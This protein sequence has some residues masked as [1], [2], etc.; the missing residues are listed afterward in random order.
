M[1]MRMSVVVAVAVLGGTWS[2]RADE[3]GAGAGAEVVASPIR[4]EVVLAEPLDPAG[5]VG[6]LV[7]YVV[8]EGSG[9][10]GRT[11]PAA[12]PFFSSPQPMFGVD[13]RGWDEGRKVVI[14][15]AC[16]A[17][18]FPGPGVALEP[19]EYRVQAVLDRKRESSSWSAEEGNLYST[20]SRFTVASGQPLVVPIELGR[21]IPKAPAPRR[22]GLRVFEMVS[23]RL[24]AFHG[25]EVVMR[26]GVVE[27]VDF[28][29]G[30]SYAA[31]YEIPGFGGT[32]RGAAR[33]ARRRAELNPGS[34]EYEL[35]RSTYLIV[36]DPESGN[37]HHLFCDS[38]VNGPR[39]AALVEELIPAL[40]AELSLIDD[41]GA[42]IVTGHSSGGW[43]SLWLAL[44]HDDVFG[45]C[46]SSSPDPV[47]FRAFQRVNI[48]EDACFYTAVEGGEEHASFTSDGSAT[49][50]IRQE[51]LSEE[52]IGPGNS[53]G[54]QWDSW[55]AAF[56][57]RGTDGEP[58][59]LFDPVTGMIDHGL[60]ARYRTHDISSMVRT[61]PRAVLP[62]FRN[63][64]RLVVGS[65]DSFDLDR[66]VVLL[67][68][69]IEKATA[70]A[71]RASLGPP[72]G[73]PHGAPPHGVAGDGPAK[74]YIEII[75]G[76]D[77]GSVFG[78][79]RMRAWPRE[80]LEHL[81]EA[82]FA[83]DAEPGAVPAAE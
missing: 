44:Q 61:S 45:A 2:V 36:L 68:E 6:R 67:R 52:V 18:C 64:I 11:P 70:A 55:F 13:V 21:E 15:S 77:H 73:S 69:E 38:L 23:P 34:A 71:E 29:P 4:F 20:P 31:I 42:R 80:M 47:D 35:A 8:R 1:R 12:G 50:T 82:G 74:G 28:D 53:S 30:R 65:E 5:A 48:Y 83:R 10:D 19:G 24:T 3:P 37:G 25:R 60:A 58:A 56:G 16:G 81:R 54:Q 59:P 62:T 43:S 14:D 66:A 76:A 63:N 79:D 9:I 72:A 41:A 51:N 7:V 39:A 22:E 78:S 26:A 40:G 75:D 27:P 46:W 33:E 49:M 17:A 32:H 57:P